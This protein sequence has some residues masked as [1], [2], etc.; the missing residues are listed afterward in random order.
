MSNNKKAIDVLFGNKDNLQRIMLDAIILTKES[1]YKDSTFSDAVEQCMYR[2]NIIASEH[3][4]A[5]LFDFNLETYYESHNN[6]LTA[7]ILQYK[8]DGH[9]D[10]EKAYM[11]AICDRFNL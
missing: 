1:L 10:G 8:I 3:V 6:E 5:E 11:Q 9:A 2:F 4:A 7:D